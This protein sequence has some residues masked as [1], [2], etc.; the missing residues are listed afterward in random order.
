MSKG[1]EG[2]RLVEDRLRTIQGSYAVLKSME[3]N[4]V[5]FQSGKLWKNYFF[6]S[7]SMEK[8]NNFPELIFW[9]TFS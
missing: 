2:F 4:F 9:H 7:V 1:I 5:I 3:K 8:D 6:W